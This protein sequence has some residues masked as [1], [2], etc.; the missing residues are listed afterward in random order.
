MTTIT[1]S[2]R[3]LLQLRLAPQPV[4]EALVSA[5]LLARHRRTSPFP[6]RGWMRSALAAAR[7]SGAEALIRWAG[8]WPRDQF[9]NFLVPQPRPDDLDLAESCRRIESWEPEAIRERLRRQYPQDVPVA[10][11]QFAVDTGAALRSFQEC[12]RDYAEVILKPYWSTI[13]ETLVD[14][15]TYRS[16]VLAAGGV[17]ELLGSLHHRVD[18]TSPE[19]TLTAPGV[20]GDTRTPER[21]LL[22]PLMFARDGVMVVDL[23]SDTTLIGYQARGA[24]NLATSANVS[25]STASD[26]VVQLLGRTRAAVMRALSMPR[27]TTALASELRLAP[28]TISE[29]L[30]VLVAC[31][32]ALRTRRA[33][34]VYYGL[35]ENGLALLSL[36]M[37][38]Q[39]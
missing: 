8:S 38:G 26:H 13:S 29:H 20:A 33:N 2:D 3:A 16:G 30:S 22:V 11:R 28:S 10:F 14:D 23:D 6:Y 37:V 25:S 17:E 27:T 24:A 7:G 18:W 39:R 15:L 12:L 35:T 5:E 31:R 32:I 9:P 36:L 34:R 1:L 19:L 21:L 4:W